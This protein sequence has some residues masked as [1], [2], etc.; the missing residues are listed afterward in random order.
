MK[1]LIFIFIIAFVLNLIWENLHVVFYDNYLGGP[2]TR[3]ILLQASVV[4]A[5]L[6]ILLSLPF[7]YKNYFKNKMW[8]IIIFGIIMAV[9][10]EWFALY[11]NWWQYNPNMPI[12]PILKVGL[13]PMIQLGILGYF[14]L[15]LSNPHNCQM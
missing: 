13:T 2:T 15:R 7:L 4:D 10:I 9:F 8:L 3:F 12:V 1:R 6:I 14:S 11:N 5:F